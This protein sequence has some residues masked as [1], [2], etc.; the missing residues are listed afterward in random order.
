MNL[1]RKEKISFGLGDF[2]NNGIFTFVST[3]LMYYYADVA[4]LELA[5][6]SLILMLGICIILLM[7]CYHLDAWYPQIEKDLSEGRM[8]NGQPI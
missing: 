6:I 1:I 7:M 4:C 3:Y 8:E 2:S 5:S